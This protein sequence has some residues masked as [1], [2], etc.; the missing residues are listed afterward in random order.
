MR[1]L[2]VC[3]DLPLTPPN[4]V[5]ELNSYLSLENM[6]IHRPLFDGINYRDDSSSCRYQASGSSI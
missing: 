3:C 5:I 1:N 4:L 2:Q 6:V